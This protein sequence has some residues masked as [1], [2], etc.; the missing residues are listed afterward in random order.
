MNTDRAYWV[1]GRSDDGIYSENLF[2]NKGKLIY[3]RE[4]DT[5]M[6]ALENLS[7]DAVVQVAKGFRGGQVRNMQKTLKRAIT[8]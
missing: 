7:Y 1:C 3:Y 4:I 8:D 5:D 6:L 2:D